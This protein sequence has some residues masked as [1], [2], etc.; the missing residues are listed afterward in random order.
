MCIYQVI[1]NV[2][3]KKLDVRSRDDA[4]VLGSWSRKALFAYGDIS[5]WKETAVI[6]A[7]TVSEGFFD[8]QQQTYDLKHAGISNRKLYCLQWNTRSPAK[9]SPIIKQK[10]TIT[11]NLAVVKVNS[12]SIDHIDAKSAQC[13]RAEVLITTKMSIWTYTCRWLAYV[14]TWPL[15]F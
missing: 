1:R 8:T 13:L 11:C 4:T 3:S 14:I 2:H 12:Y 10:Y 9:Y 5:E 7:R 6:N 15:T